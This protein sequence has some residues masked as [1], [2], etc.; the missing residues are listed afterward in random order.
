MVAHGRRQS[1]GTVESW[2][3]PGI[4]VCAGLLLVFTRSHSTAAVF[5]FTT[6]TP[7]EYKNSWFVRIFRIMASIPSDR[8]T[9]RPDETERVATVPPSPSLASSLSLL[10]LTD[11]SQT[12][13]STTQSAFLPRSSPSFILL[14]SHPA[15]TLVSPLVPISH[16]PPRA[17]H[18]YSG[19]FSSSQ[20]P[21]RET[22][23]V[24]LSNRISE[25]FLGF[26]DVK[27]DFVEWMLGFSKQKQLELKTSFATTQIKRQI[28]E[29]RKTM[30]PLI[31]KGEDVFGDKLV[32]HAV[33]SL[34]CTNA[35]IAV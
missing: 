27:S 31:I 3:G 22:R 17:D 12:I 7:A 32:R 5:A 10:G 25:S 18:V 2:L 11:A 1:A 26:A 13:G 29:Y 34:Y 16:S 33:C 23:R 28:A 4:A 6:G 9:S 35:C 15:T 8:S 24:A 21:N 14:R 20:L 19:H 30:S